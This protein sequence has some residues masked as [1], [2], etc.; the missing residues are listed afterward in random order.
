MMNSQGNPFGDAQ[1]AQQ[2]ELRRR[3][4]RA[5]DYD[6]IFELVK[7]VVEMEL[8][9]H[10]AG[11]TL[12]LASM[13]N[14]VGA[15]HP[16]ASNVIVLN[17]SLVSAFRRVTKDPREINAFVFMVL[18]HEYLHSLGYLDEHQVRRMSQRMCANTLGSDHLTVKLAVGNWLE[19]Y[20]QLEK[21]T[22]P[23]SKEYEVVTKFDTS[24]TSYIG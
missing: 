21:V 1:R 14:T 3:V 16:I 12:V 13:Q 10:R 6:E 5:Q 7:R 22:L 9:Q 2:S 20:P 11:L 23:T 18:M 17:K 4:D 24:S 8:G 15:Y 19:M